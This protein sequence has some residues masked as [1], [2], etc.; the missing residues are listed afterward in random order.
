MDKIDFEEDLMELVDAQVSHLKLQLQQRIEDCRKQNEEIRNQNRK[1]YKSEHQKQKRAERRVG[2]KK[3]RE[4]VIRS[5]KEEHEEYQRSQG[6]CIFYKTRK[7]DFKCTNPPTANRSDEICHQCRVLQTQYIKSKEKTN[8]KSSSSAPSVVIDENF[9]DPADIIPSS[10]VVRKPSRKSTSIKTSQ[11]S[12]VPNTKTQS[13]SVPNV[14]KTGIPPD[15]KVEPI[16]FPDSFDMRLND[17]PEMGT[18]ERLAGLRKEVVANSNWR[19]KYSCMA[20]H[21]VTGDL[22][23]CNLTRVEGYVL[24]RKHIKPFWNGGPVMRKDLE[25]KFIDMSSVLAPI[26]V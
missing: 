17:I 26:Q 7:P 18:P 10:D 1:E 6:L 8:R 9:E 11:P 16:P 14:S 23:N 22:L 19:L 13:S 4:E 2:A 15:K 21:K 3:E 5:A 20:E 12:R 24:C 25:Q